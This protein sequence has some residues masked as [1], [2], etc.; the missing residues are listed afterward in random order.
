MAK[1]FSL[2]FTDFSFEDQRFLYQ[3]F[4]IDS[5]HQDAL[6]KAANREELTQ[7]LTADENK[8][9]YYLGY[10]AAMLAYDVVYLDLIPVAN[11]GKDYYKM[12]MELAPEVMLSEDF[13]MGWYKGLNSLG[14][15]KTC[16]FTTK[17]DYGLDDLDFIFKKYA[18]VSESLSR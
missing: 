13:D 12:K 5:I 8:K 18:M 17:M 15:D 6:S 9:A 4:F 2:K 11:Y 7:I 16:L 14:P 1:K 10:L 3:Y